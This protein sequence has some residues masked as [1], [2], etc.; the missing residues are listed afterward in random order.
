[1]IMS[2][3]A[4]R[5]AVLLC[6]VVIAGCPIVDPL[7]DAGPDQSVS[8][9]TKVTIEPRTFVPT[10]TVKTYTWTQIAG[11]TVTTKTS[12]KGALTFAAPST[13]IQLKLEFQIIVA[14][15]KGRVSQPDTIV[16]TVNQNKFFG[17]AV[18]SDADYE[19][20]F[21]YFNQITPE[22]AGK[23]GSVEATRDVMVWD[24]VDSAYKFAKDH[25][26]LF[27]FHTM[28][29]GQ[30]QPAWLDSL[31]P[32]E[33][34]EEIDEWMTA[35]AQRYPDIDLIDV[36][37]EPLNTPATYREAL[38]GAGTTGYD[39]VVKAFQMARAHFPH[40]KLILNE[41]NTLMLDQFTTN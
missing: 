17:T 16:V 8:E 1:M 28:I 25:K 5:Y 13:D 31:T 10:G 38:G 41:Y 21:K 7:V 9:G 37:N 33:Q 26:L 40:A 23:W 19:H 35:V 20:L 36:V 11:P 14:D 4:L 27:K 6:A 15:N 39:W 24:G 12:K 3:R 22:N 30:Q 34:L 32:Q 18:G 2:F 29:W